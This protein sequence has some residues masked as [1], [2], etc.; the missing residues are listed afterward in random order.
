MSSKAKRAIKTYPDIN[1]YELVYYFLFYSAHIWLLSS[2]SFVVIDII[3]QTIRKNNSLFIKTFH[4]VQRFPIACVSA[5][6]Q[7]DRATDI[8]PYT[9]ANDHTKPGNVK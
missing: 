8:M 6:A 1:S 3:T 5:F 2:T 7:R 9:T 4:R